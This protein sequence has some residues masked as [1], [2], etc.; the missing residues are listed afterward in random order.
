MGLTITSLLKESE[1]NAREASI[2][3]PKNLF[4]LLLAKDYFDLFLIVTD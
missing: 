4:Q 1:L 3:V 2:I